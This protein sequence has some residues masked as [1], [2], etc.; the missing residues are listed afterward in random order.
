MKALETYYLYYGDELKVECPIGSE[1]MM[2]L[3][4]LARELGR[5]SAACSFPTRIDGAPAMKTTGVSPAILTGMTCRC[6]TSTCTATQ[7]AGLERTIKP[8]G[9]LWLHDASAAPPK[10]SCASSIKPRNDYRLS[11]LSVFLDNMASFHHN[12]L[13]SG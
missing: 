7:D 5:D 6:S 3:F 2:N 8:D 13:G 12:M 1:R 9:Q 4:E 10:R 11:R